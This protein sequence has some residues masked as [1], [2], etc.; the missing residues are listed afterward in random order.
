[1]TKFEQACIDEVKRIRELLQNFDAITSFSFAVNAS[2]RIRDGEVELT[3][4]VGNYSPLV[5]ANSVDG[6]LNE[7]MRREGWQK[8]NNPIR[9]GRVDSN[10]EISL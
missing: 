5:V 10:E 4:G 1:M 8:R 6:A 2:G 7:Y 3:F 9:I